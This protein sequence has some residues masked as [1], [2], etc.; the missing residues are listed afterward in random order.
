MEFDLVRLAIRMGIRF[1]VAMF[2]F[3]IVFLIDKV[4]K[5]NNDWDIR[6]IIIIAS[7]FTIFLTIIDAIGV[8]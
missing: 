8:C 6:Y 4:T 3:G 2:T 1:L 7:L 5:T